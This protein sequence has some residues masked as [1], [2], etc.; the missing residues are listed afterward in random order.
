MCSTYPRYTDV[1]HV[2]AGSANA[3]TYAQQTS[4][5]RTETLDTDTSTHYVLRR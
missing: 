4:Q 1:A 2:F 3:R 5:N